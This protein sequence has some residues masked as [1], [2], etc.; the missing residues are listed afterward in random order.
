VT[1]TANP[2]AAFAQPLDRDQLVEP[3]PSYVKN[4]VE[5]GGAAGKGIKVFLD[6]GGVWRTSQHKH[7]L[8]PTPNEDGTHDDLGAGWTRV[9]TFAEAYAGKEGLT[10]WLVNNC[11]KGQLLDPTLVADVQRT[12]LDG[13]QE[14][15]RKFRDYRERALSLAGARQSA[16]LGSMLHDVNAKLDTGELAM[17]DVPVLWRNHIMAR[18]A[19]LARHSVRQ[20]PE[21]VER[22]VWIPDYGGLVG[23]FDRV[24]QYGGRWVVLDDKTGSLDYAKDSIGNQLA[25]YSL[26]RWM[27]NPATH[28]F[29]PL[30]EIDRDVALVLHLPAKGEPADVELHEVNIRDSR[31]HGLPL[32]AS[33]RRRQ[34]REQASR[35][36]T[37]LDKAELPGLWEAGILA[38][39][40]ETELREVWQ[41]ITE[42]GAATAELSSLAK[43]QMLQFPVGEVTLGLEQ[44][45]AFEKIGTPEQ[46]AD[47]ADNAMT[48]EAEPIEVARS[49][50]GWSTSAKDGSPL[51]PLADKAAGQRG[52]G[53][54]GRTGHK[55]G[56]AK[57]WGEQDP[58]KTSA[59]ARMAAG[60]RSARTLAQAAAEVV[61]HGIGEPVSV[62][63][64]QAAC[65][66][67]GAFTRD[68]ITGYMV[69]AHCGEE[70]PQAR[71]AREAMAGFSAV[72][73]QQVL[74]QREQAQ[75][76]MQKDWP[77]VSDAERAVIE[78]GYAP[79]TT[80]PDQ[81]I[82]AEAAFARLA[83]SVARAEAGKA[84]VGDEAIL[85]GKPDVVH[86]V[87]DSSLAQLAVEVGSGEASRAEFDQVAEDLP[88]AVA[89]AERMA[90]IVAAVRACSTKAEL[91]VIRD[92]A[93]ERGVWTSKLTQLG[94]YLIETG[95]IQ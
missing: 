30:P 63:Q 13:S 4:A 68:A 54:C 75:T 32:C 67:A 57:C 48:V 69:C 15:T 56:S 93:V 60:D 9:T 58:A 26:A 81:P 86:E 2:P 24:V 43:D 84:T 51:A 62:E 66:H 21:L 23:T 29:E 17:A 90:G 95:K 88:L 77:P 87:W 53:V 44:P 64:V 8:L 73:A 18:R 28:S 38:A 35:L 72:E 59:V 39:Q 85:S 80:L 5:R 41:T 42:V 14:S 49:R 20:V 83:E 76:E 6:A 3:M 70:T 65:P 27:W 31:E 94:T 10:N 11:M 91:R 47:A 34:S 33:V 40:T 52:C 25:L 78:R 36:F 82:P 92:K 61:S 71:A 19:C 1:T 79:V 16:N 7:Y 50:E 46:Q 37:T 45:D 89:A 22:I 12:P 55:R 74:D